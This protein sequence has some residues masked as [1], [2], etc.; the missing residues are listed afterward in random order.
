MNQLHV[1]ESLLT[2]ADSPLASQQI[3]GILWISEVRRRVHKSSWS[4]SQTSDMGK[5]ALHSN[6]LQSVAHL[7][8]VQSISAASKVEVKKMSLCTPWGHI[9]GAEV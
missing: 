9:R 1:S 8:T 5:D 6:D 7:R 4:I 3:L 2:Q